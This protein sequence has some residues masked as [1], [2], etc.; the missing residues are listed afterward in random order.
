[1]FY[2]SRSGV[3]RC[4]RPTRKVTC[5]EYSYVSLGLQPSQSTE[6]FMS[7]PWCWGGNFTFGRNCWTQV[8]VPERYFASCFSLEK[9]SPV[10]PVSPFEV[11]WLHTWCHISNLTARVAD[12]QLFCTVSAFL[13]KLA[14]SQPLS[15]KCLHLGP[16]LSDSPAFPRLQGSSQRRS[17]SL[18]VQ[19]LQEFA[20]CHGREIEPLDLHQGDL[21][22][23][24][25][26]LSSCH[27][28][29]RQ[30][31]DGCQ[32][33][34]GHPRLLDVQVWTYKFG[35]LFIRLQLSFFITVRKWSCLPSLEEFFKP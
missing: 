12:Q 28:Q 17:G 27:W 34:W 2:F 11:L 7:I 29:E 14:G 20:E 10:G 22:S 15:S 19:L 9:R 6:Q 4:L 1:M 3:L 24:T 21:W 8:R 26:V 35:S 23:S 16:W 30:C 31:L 5:R 33:T 32:K 25:K 18:K 13:E